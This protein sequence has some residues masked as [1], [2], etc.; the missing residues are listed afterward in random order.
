[1]DT[2]VFG[3]VLTATGS[4]WG[5]SPVRVRPCWANEKT[6][7]TFNLLRFYLLK[8]PVSHTLI[9]M[10]SKNTSSGLSS[11]KLVKLSIFRNRYK[12]DCRCKFNTLA[13]CETLPFW[14]S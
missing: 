10:F 7:A 12:R 14:L 9:L 3:Y 13:A 11:D 4:H 5:L 8:A 2:L 6:L 1:M